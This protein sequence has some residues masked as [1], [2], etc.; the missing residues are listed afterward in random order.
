MLQKKIDLKTRI[1][2]KNLTLNNVIKETKRV[3]KIGEKSY[4]MLSLIFKF[5]KTN[6]LKHIIPSRDI[7][8]IFKRTLS[9]IHHFGSIDQLI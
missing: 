9:E 4:K 1:N 7:T 3:I 6:L 8:T 2:I 5:K